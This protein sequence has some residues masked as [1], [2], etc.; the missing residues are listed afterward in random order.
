VSQPTLSNVAIGGAPPADVDSD[1]AARTYRKAAWRLL[2]F[3]FLCYVVAY[4][5]RPNIGFAQ[6][7][8]KQDLGFS[9]AVYGLG[10]G[11]FFVGYALCEVPS[12]LIL[13]RTGTRATLTR[14]LL[15]W[16]LVSVAMIHVSSAKGFYHAWAFTDP[17]RARAAARACDAAPRSGP[18]H[19]VPVGIKDVIDT[20]DMPTEYGSTIHRG[21]RP[22]RD[23]AC[24]SLIRRAEA[25]CW[26]RRSAPSL[27]CTSPARRR[28]R[29][30]RATRRVV[31]RA[32][33]PQQWRTGMCRSRLARR[34]LVQLSVLP[35]T[36]A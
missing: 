20:C 19:G 16:G 35:P 7:Q 22:S 32:V 17:E 10:A 29:T 13:K 18:L 5:D 36:V 31:H 3:L 30:I 26:A 8:M 33:R 9:D 2:P 24:V 11:V 12:N 15:L 4:L 1:A 6:L 21:H 25:S 14:I 28:I 23:A 34:P 27:R